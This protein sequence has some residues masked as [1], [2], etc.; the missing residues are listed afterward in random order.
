MKRKTRYL[1][2]H[3]I[4]TP[5]VGTAGAGLGEHAVVGSLHTAVGLTI[6][7]VLRA[8][9]ATTFAWAQLSHD[10]LSGLLDDDHTQYRLE[11]ADHTHQTTGLQAGQLDHGLALLGLLD[12]DHAQYL[13]EEASGGT[14]AETPDHIHQAAA[15]CG[16]LDHGLALDGLG[17]DDHTQYFLLAGETT[18]A[19]LYSGADLLL[20]SDVGA[21]LKAALYGDSGQ[22]VFVSVRTPL[23]DTASGNQTL[24]PAGDLIIN[25]IGNDALPGTGYDINL[26]S[27]AKKYLTLHAAE[28]WV[29][30]LVAQNT[31]ATIGGRI[32]VGPTTVLTSDLAPADTTMY[33]K[34]NEMASGDRV[35]LEA[36]GK[37]EFIAITS[38]PGGTGPY[39]YTI[40]RNLDGSGANQWYAGDA[41]FNTGTTGDGFIDIYS[42]RSIKSATQYGPAIVGN[43]RNSATYNDWTERWAIGN[44]NGVYGYGVTTY[45]VAL[46]EYLAGE[47]HLTID[48]T[49]GIRFFAGLSTLIA[50]WNGAVMT[51]GQTTLEHLRV[52]DTEIQFKDGANV[53]TNLAAGVLTLGLVSGG[54]YLD[55]SSVGIKM[56]GGGVQHVDLASSGT[57]WIGDTPTTERLQWDITNGLQIFNANNAATIKFSPAGDAEITGQ[58]T[59]PSGGSIKA[60]T[61]V[62]DSTLDGFQ[63]DSGEI[64]GQE[65]GVDQVVISATDGKLKAGAGA[66]TLD[67]TGI[68]IKTSIDWASWVRWIDLGNIV[69]AGCYG[70]GGTGLDDA[71]WIAKIYD[72]DG[73][74]CGTL[75]L[76]QE[77][78]VAAISELDLRL[79]TAGRKLQFFDALTEIW[80]DASGNLTLKD[81]V[82]GTK[83]LT[84]LLGEVTGGVSAY[85]AFVGGTPQNITVTYTRALSGTPTA[86]VATIRRDADF[87]PTDSSCYVKS[88]TSTAAIVRAISS[89]TRSLYIDVLAVVA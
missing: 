30:T 40:T 45:G 24:Q 42:Y 54:E 61:G 53:Y 33:V 10:E 70:L 83:T 36:E 9:G 66:V 2:P 55:I 58:L 6:G 57:F 44:L 31:I 52:S 39:S 67:A 49:D 23:I 59:I 79:T 77:L 80:K 26:G 15:S 37:V 63:I 21:T 8:S 89:V 16:K 28:L 50:Q 25:P 5:M 13:K 4:P 51:L 22:G 81:A 11:S 86:V 38:A 82:A 7:Y 71:M 12:D 32:L 46:G 1:A 62:K 72:K 43:V 41:V 27:L 60:G 75:R 78:D 87:P 18:D 69:R 76:D 73:I 56:Y 14:A 3:T 64:V 17:D 68:G 35:Y 34:H 19:K 20:Y 88:Y 84:Q 74:L 48:S 85:T 47:N 65:N 29:E